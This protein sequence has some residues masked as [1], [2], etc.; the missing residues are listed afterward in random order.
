MDKLRKELAF[1]F[2]YFSPVKQIT[3]TA[4]WRGHH[5]QQDGR[6]RFNSK[7]VEM[8]VIVYYAP[9][10]HAQEEIKDEFYDQLEQ[11]IGTTP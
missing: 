6:E 9:T 2:F 11:A 7:F 5:C 8:T 4:I 1:Y 3:I 10:E